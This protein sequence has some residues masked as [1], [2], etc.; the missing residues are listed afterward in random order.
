MDLHDVKQMIRKARSGLPPM[1]PIA[2]GGEPHYALFAGGNEPAHE[3]A[4]RIEH[5]DYGA[6]MAYPVS[7]ADDD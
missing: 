7:L 3:Q 4:V 5:P 2:I 6:G 1:E